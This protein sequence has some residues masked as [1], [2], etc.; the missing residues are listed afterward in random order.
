MKGLKK[1]FSI[2]MI[3][4]ILCSFSISASA[5][6]SSASPMASSVTAEQ[7][8]DSILS[9]GMT[10]ENIILTKSDISQLGY[11]NAPN[12]MNLPFNE[13][14]V[15]TTGYVSDIFKEKGA[16]SSF[17]G[18]GNSY[19][20]ELYQNEGFSSSTYD[21]VELSFDLVPTKAALTFD[22]FF[23]STEYNQPKQYNDTFALWVIDSET[24]ERF[25][26]AKTPFG[27]V[28]NVQNTVTKDSNDNMLYTENSKY[29]NAI[30]NNKYN[31]YNFGMLG[32]STMFSA[33]AASLKNS[34]GEPVIQS[35][36]KVTL[37]F[38]IADSAD[39][40]MDSAVFIR[41]NSI[42]FEEADTKEYTVTFDANGGS[43]DVK[44]AKTGTDGTLESLPQAVMDG[45][46]TFDGWYTKPSG[47]EKIDVSTVFEADTTVYAHW[48]ADE[49]TIKFDVDGGNEISDIIYNSESS[50]VIPAA[51]KNGFTFEG[52]QIVS[53]DG[54]WNFDEVV[55]AGTSVNGM[56]GNLTLK[57]VWSENPT[58]PETTVSV[59]QTTQPTQPTT[60]AQATVDESVK[61]VDSANVQTG[62]NTSIIV[63]SMILIACAGIVWFT[64]KRKV[65]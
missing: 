6:E 55:V 48:K 36:K 8:V 45:N 30:L 3:A 1:V 50:D 43:C 52:W 54:N 63:I 16:S 64:T 61:V 22:F 18:N 42:K 27:K 31:G 15:L 14:I 46:Y 4:A 11:F 51:S 2:T 58:E 53:G 56:Y 21:A 24:G 9:E 60:K 39:H 38:A 33:D 47:G 12:D 44:T 26:I 28:V 57:A 59:P 41:S 10:A 5:V 20:T 35:G 29:Y 7:A 62:F 13:G 19:L 23:A 37:S 65:D 34:K 40:V 25:N 49:Y 17:N 32:V